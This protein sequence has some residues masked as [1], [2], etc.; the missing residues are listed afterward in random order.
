MRRGILVITESLLL[1]VFSVPVL[2]TALSVEN[3]G[4]SIGLG[5]ADLRTILVNIISWALGLLG[6]IAVIMILIGGFQWL[7]SG[8]DEDRVATAKRTI[9]SA[10]VGLLIILLSWALVHFVI[11]TTAN[12]TGA[13]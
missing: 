1:S 12:V 6:I 8:G 11:R 2:A 7:I 5:T 10:I 3:V 13:I 4:A 9:S